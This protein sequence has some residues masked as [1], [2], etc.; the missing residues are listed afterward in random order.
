MFDKKG[1]NIRSYKGV[2]PL[3]VMLPTSLTNGLL[4]DFNSKVSLNIR[5]LLNG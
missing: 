2:L 1:L 5:D 4:G 3:L